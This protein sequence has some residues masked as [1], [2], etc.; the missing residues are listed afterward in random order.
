MSRHDE[1]T[2]AGLTLTPQ[3]LI[4]FEHS[5]KDAV[6]GFLK[7]TSYSLFFPQ[8]LPEPLRRR[9]RAPQYLPETHELILPLD[10]GDENETGNHDEPLGYFV[11]RGVRLR[12]PRTLPRYLYA[13]AQ[14]QMQKLL[15]YKRSVRDTLTGLYNRDYFLKRTAREIGLIQAGLT[16][17]GHGDLHLSDADMGAYAAGFGII[18]LDLD[19]FQWINE[20]YGY[21]TGDRIVAEVGTMLSRICPSHVTVARLINDRFAVLMPGAGPHT[22]FQLAELIR[23]SVA[24]LAV[25]ADCTGDRLVLTASLGTALHPQNLEG[26]QFMQGPTEQAR[27]LLRKANKALFTAK[28]HGRNRIFAF[29]DLVRQGGRVVEALPMGRLYVS[30]GTDVGARIGQRFL[31]REGTSREAQAVLVEKERLSGSYPSAFKGEV[32]LTEV[33]SEFGFA[34]IL[35]LSDP[36]ARLKAGDTLILVNEEENPF[37]PES[38]GNNAPAKPETVTGLYR[39]RDFLTLFAQRRAEPEVFSLALVR[40][41]EEP[42]ERSGSFQAWMDARLRTVGELLAKVLGGA[43]LGGRYGLGGAMY[44]LPHMPA[45]DAAV[46]FTRV[47]AQARDRHGFGLAVGVA[48][49]PFLHQDRADLPEMAHMALEHARLLPASGPQI[50]VFNS[51]SLNIEA[52]RCHGEGDLYNAI[53]RYQLALLADPGNLLARNSL[54]ICLAQLGRFDQA[55]AEFAQVAEAEPKNLMARYNLGWS[56]LR[57]GNTEGAQE[58]F[59]AAHALDPTNVYPLVRLAGLAERRGKPEEARRYYEQAA[60]LPG[61]EPLALRHLAQLALGRGDSEAAREHLHLALKANPNDAQAMHLLAKLYLNSGQDPQIA[62]VLARQSASLMPERTA[63]WDLLERAL[64]DQ[65]KNTEA[66]TVAG[67]RRSR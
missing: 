56:L 32:V 34:E 15:L 9:E 36:S 40:V 39:H 18:V 11:A 19:H 29:S 16:P 52:D 37:K 31:V 51:V 60:A 5:L 30:L 45:A 33:Q 23:S 2:S 57:L 55:R 42:R 67:C 24:Q 6:A 28:Y 59:K 50:T 20:R 35:S 38:T 21:A 22:C 61:G 26:P 3:D 14:A 62:E 49:Y 53:Q 7:F 17:T 10:L 46:N 43:P 48:Q 63:F 66:D 54:G 65:G 41:L 44:F 58:A 25:H 1:L 47:D 4:D 64:R 13:L 12:A 8:S 27:I